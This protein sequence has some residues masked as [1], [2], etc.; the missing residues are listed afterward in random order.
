[1][2]MPVTDRTRHR[3]TG[4]I[5]VDL[6]PAEAF[7]LF[8]PSGERDW[9]AGWEPRFPVPVD[10]DSEPG[11]VFWTDGHGQ[12]ITW[13]VVDRE[14]GHRISYA[15]VSPDS[16]AGTVTV[17]LDGCQGRSQV[18]VTY[19]LTPLNGAAEP[20]LR[21]FAAHYQDYLRSWQDAISGW[22]ATTRN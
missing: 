15:R 18:S 17:Q 20:E 6:P 13:M 8:T 22:L 4:Q 7:R 5:T 16:H 12:R 11:T 1:M 21:R 19:Q 9:A 2:S 10:D 14:P 3:L